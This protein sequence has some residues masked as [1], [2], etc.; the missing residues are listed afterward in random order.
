M[1]RESRGKKAPTG[2]LMVLVLELKS[3]LHI[4]YKNI[5]S[6]CAMIGKVGE[7]ENFLDN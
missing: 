6:A 2:N 5:S 4:F 7:P 3:C 1:A